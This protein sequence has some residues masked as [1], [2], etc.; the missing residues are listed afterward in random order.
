M[1]HDDI[2]YLL[3]SAEKQFCDVIYASPD[4]LLSLLLFYCFTVSNKLQSLKYSNSVVWNR[5]R[6]TKHYERVRWQYMQS[7]AKMCLYAQP[8]MCSSF[9]VTHTRRWRSVRCVQSK[10]HKKEWKGIIGGREGQ[11][12]V[13]GKGNG[14]EHRDT[15][16]HKV[17]NPHN[18]FHLQIS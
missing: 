16:L 8:C 15:Y 3:Y 11:N 14:W 12:R 2:R 9:H 4:L 1:M 18:Y 10:S 7:R 17:K 13:G 5:R 6:S